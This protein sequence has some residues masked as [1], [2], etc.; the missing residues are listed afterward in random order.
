ML[1]S[2]VQVNKVQVKLEKVK[3][4]KETSPHSPLGRYVVTAY[5]FG[6][7]R[8]VGVAYGIPGNKS[9]LALRMQKYMQDRLSNLKPEVA[10]D[11]DGNTYVANDYEGLAVRG[12][13][14]DADLRGH[15]Y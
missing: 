13:H 2:K 8:S 15:G 7:N 4:T 12:R 3:I 5:W 14:L 11:I 6:V 1:L 9:K 10:V